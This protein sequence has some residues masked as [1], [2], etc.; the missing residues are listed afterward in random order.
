MRHAAGQTV[1]S[2][3]SH[4][5]TR[6]TRDDRITATMGSYNKITH[7]L[8]GLG[9]D[10]SFYKAEAE[11]QLSRQVLQGLVSCLLHYVVAK[12]AEI[13]RSVHFSR[14]QDGRTLWTERPVDPLSGSVPVGRTN[15]CAHVPPEQHGT[16]RWPY[17]KFYSRLSTN[18]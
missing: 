2:S 9:G 8:A 17:V 1:K 3:V 7:E 4:S 6:D 16:T 18:I 15:K 11:S 14:N 13:R 5:W 10:A 12:Y